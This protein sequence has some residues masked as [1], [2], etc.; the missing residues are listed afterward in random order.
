MD[1][2]NIK[3][4]IKFFIISISSLLVANIT[5]AAYQK[6]LSYCPPVES[7]TKQIGGYNW[8]TK[9]NGWSGFYV[10]PQLGKG[11]SYTLKKLYKVQWIQSHNTINSTGF[12]QCD[13]IG[14][15]A[16]DAKN[17]D[18]P[19]EVIHE[20]IR[21][22]QKDAKGAYR[23]V[24]GVKTSDSS[25]PNSFWTCKHITHFPK[26]ACTCYATNPSNCGFKAH[27]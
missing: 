15:Y 20:I 10:Y 1:N 13:Y 24:P 27:S 21:L 8:E 2:L 12:I 19:N 18:K 11:H 9:I 3:K 17:P 7:I 23:P 14:D 22:E 26:V 4:I 16:I 25:N 6:N 5:N